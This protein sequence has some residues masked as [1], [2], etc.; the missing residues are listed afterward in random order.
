[1]LKNFISKVKDPGFSN[2]LVVTFEFSI[3]SYELKTPTKDNK[4]TSVEHIKEGENYANYILFPEVAY[5]LV[6]YASNIL[7]LTNAQWCKL[8]RPG[9]GYNVFINSD[10]QNYAIKEDHIIVF[11]N[12][13]SLKSKVI[14]ELV[15]GSD[16]T[17]GKN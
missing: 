17:Q 2:K 6:I 16:M 15:L 13:Q 12:V 14:P 7:H 10:T 9:S 5:Y 3:L 8:V 4:L 1:M 11:D